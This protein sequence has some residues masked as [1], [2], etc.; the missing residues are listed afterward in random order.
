MDKLEVSQ[1]R[2]EV[3]KRAAREGVREGE[4]DNG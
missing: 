3:G 1:G 4:G 2:Y